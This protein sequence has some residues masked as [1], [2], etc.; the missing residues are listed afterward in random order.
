MRRLVADLRTGCPG[1]ERHWQQRGAAMRRSSRKRID[2]PE[3]GVVELDCDVLGV[4]DADQ[5]LIV[6][7]AAPGT[8]AADALALLRVLGTQD[9]SRQPR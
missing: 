2:H 7:S 6:Y 4:P 8:P 9:V 1:F 5:R 3:L